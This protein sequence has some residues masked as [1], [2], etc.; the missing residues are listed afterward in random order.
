MAD[1]MTA[2]Q[3][4]GYPIVV[5]IGLAWFCKYMIDQQQKNVD[6]MFEMYAKSNE[7]NREAIK[8]NT[9]ALNRLC[10]RLDKEEKE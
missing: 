3:T 7:E 10:E 9:E 8:A 5:S 1:V 2:I 4:L 6:K